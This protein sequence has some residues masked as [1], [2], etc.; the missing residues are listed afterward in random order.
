VEEEPGRPGSALPLDHF[1]RVSKAVHAL[2]PRASDQGLLRTACDELVDGEVFQGSWIGAPRADQ[3]LDYLAIAGEQMP[4]YL[5]QARIR[6]DDTPEGS[7]PVGR[8][9][10]SGQP[11]V[12]SD[13]TQ[14]PGMQPWREAAEYT[15]GW[16]SAAAFPVRRNGRIWGIWT[17]YARPRG[18]FDERTATLG[19]LTAD[20]LGRELDWREAD[21]RAQLHSAFY[22]SLAR[23]GELA[24]SA[25]LSREAA[26]LDGVCEA[27]LATELFQVAWIS[28]LGE[29]RLFHVRAAFGPGADLAR[30]AS[31]G[32]DSNS[33]LVG[34][35]AWHTGACVWSNDYLDEPALEDW[36]KPWRENLAA[37]GW[38]S[39][40]AAPISRHGRQWGVLIVVTA[41]PGTFTPTSGKL[42]ER[43]ARG[44]GHALDYRDGVAAL[45]E[46]RA[47][48]AAL[49]NA[50]DAVRRHVQQRDEERLLEGFC[51][52]ITDGTL[53]N[54]AAAAVPGAQGA[55]EVRGVSGS[56]V[57][58]LQAGGLTLR[59]PASR[60]A[61]IAWHE[62]RLTFCAN[63]PADPSLERYRAGEVTG[64]GNAYAARPVYR[65]GQ[66]WGVLAVG[67]PEG[68][69]LREETA[70][71]FARVAQLL[72]DGLTEID[73][74]WARQQTRERE[75]W[76]ATH[77]ALTGIGNRS[78]VD[79]VLPRA[80]ARARRAGS[81]MAVAYLDL[82]G[83][84]HVN[85]SHGHRFGDE[86]LKQVAQRALASLRGTDTLV[87]WGGDEFLCILENLHTVDD[88][89]RP[90]ENLLDAISRP[91]LIEA[92]E[93]AV[94]SSCGLA[95][96]PE[97]TCQPEA[98]IRCADLALYSHKTRKHDPDRPLFARFRPGLTRPP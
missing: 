28:E 36:L 1:Y 55:V 44:I 47:F 17:I 78:V 12:V 37:L 51:A 62:A 89:R 90:L 8:A 71:L 54:C 42:L 66:L 97:D 60:I 14:D 77:D 43:L 50:H 30:E 87:R 31:F 88:A 29:D 93:F 92:R 18:A 52:A 63:V 82:D 91:T 48:Y 80:V 53:F 95:L 33:S 5:Q 23:V 76:L 73:E 10:R 56:H 83:F 69:E 3:G 94:G 49:A 59:A 84:K 39:A 85:D 68:L 34:A 64:D 45:S 27:L 22:Q 4:A 13:W 58:C 98:L 96:Y 38:G 25:D 2:D 79:A 21:A 65:G 16:Q 86:L 7:G 74:R 32:P 9:W 35:R 57:Q 19:Q 61:D 72:G 24:H 70:A 41:P 75:R 20:M 40:A 6:V 15:G 46:S 67:F 81:M 26:L 11:V